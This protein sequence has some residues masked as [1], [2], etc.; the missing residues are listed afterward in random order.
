MDGRN[1]GD[2]LTAQNLNESDSNDP[3]VAM[4]DQSQRVISYNTGSWFEIGDE[5]TAKI[6]EAYRR[7]AQQAL[8]KAMITKENLHFYFSFSE[9]EETLYLAEVFSALPLDTD[10]ALIV[11]IKPIKSDIEKTVGE[12]MIWQDVGMLVRTMESLTNQ[13]VPFTMA[14]LTIQPFEKAFQHIALEE[15]EFLASLISGRILEYFDGNQQLYQVSE[16][17]FALILLGKATNEEQWEEF[18]SSINRPVL[19]EGSEWL[20]PVRSGVVNGPD[21]PFKLLHYAQQAL[22]LAERNQT[23]LRFH[24]ERA[25]STLEKDLTYKDVQQQM[26]IH[27]EPIHDAMA[28]EVIG[29]EASLHWDHPVFGMIPQE[30]FI[31]ELEKSGLMMKVG[32]DTFCEICSHLKEWKRAGFDRIKVHLNVLASQL[33]L[34]G[35]GQFIQM[36]E[37]EQVNVS[38]FVIEI[39]ETIMMKDHDHTTQVIEKMRQLGCCVCIDRFGAGSTD[40]TVLNR[41]EVD[42]LKVDPGFLR[43]LNEKG[44]EVLKSI[45]ALSHQLG[46]KLMVEGV[47]V[48][49]HQAL[50][51]NQHCY[52]MQGLYFCQPI[53]HTEVQAYLEQL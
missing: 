41:L 4:L 22:E 35:V 30:E 21:H 32:Y 27:Y 16:G 20:V 37:E 40:L 18:I 31:S 5:F 6:S 1:I 34:E 15:R 29:L 11:L 53:A 46:I 38:D 52:D 9:Q 26:T 47:D 7:E 8:H 50:L 45:I 33:S 12:Q 14:M 19:M 28:A 49:E 24:Q 13:D 44:E 10:E 2:E 17:T 51:M 23:L 25:F 3:I 48:A 42:A 39:T 36:I 43:H